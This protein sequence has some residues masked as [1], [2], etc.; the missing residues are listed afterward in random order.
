M[1]T[2]EVTKPKLEEVTEL[3]K[4]GKK[5][6]AINEESAIKLQNIL[7]QAVYVLNLERMNLERVFTKIERSFS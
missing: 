3:L 7:N 5:L 1:E 2:K 6:N 4:K